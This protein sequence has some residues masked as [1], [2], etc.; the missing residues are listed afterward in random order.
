LPIIET[1]G[2]D[3][4]G[5]IPTNVISITDGQ[6]FLETDIFYSGIKPA[7]NI[8]LS[9]S[10]V[11]RA[12]QSSI[13]SLICGPFKL[14]WSRFKT[15]EIL[16]SFSDDLDDLTLSTIER[17]LRL[18]EVLTQDV[19]KVSYLDQQI[20]LILSLV[21]GGLNAISVPRVSNFKQSL[22]RAFFSAIGLASSIIFLLSGLINGLQRTH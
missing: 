5:Y 13:M 16:Q 15:V 2:N 10:R 21:S 7:I 19:H 18:V 11:G 20:V 22:R 17:G 14:M 6:I 8:G 1:Q 3:I 12:A 4:S 9:V